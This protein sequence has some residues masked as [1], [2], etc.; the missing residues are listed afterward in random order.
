M[1][2][3]VTLHF[4]IYIFNI[5][6]SLWQHSSISDNELAIP[7]SIAIPCLSIV[8]CYFIQSYFHISG[9]YS[10]EPKWDIFLTFEKHIEEFQEFLYLLC[11]DQEDIL[12]YICK[13]SIKGMFHKQV[14]KPMS[15]WQVTRS[16]CVLPNVRKIFR[17][18]TMKMWLSNKDVLKKNKGNYVIRNNNKIKINKI[19]L[20]GECCCHRLTGILNIYRKMNAD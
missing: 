3:K 17:F 16:P 4:S 19:V 11:F 13:L 14:T 20:R 7:L 6:V 10:T 2:F 15:P 1:I 12:S 18:R 8:Y 9:N 5:P